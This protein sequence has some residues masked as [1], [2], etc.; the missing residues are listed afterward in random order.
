MTTHTNYTSEEWKILC[1]APLSVGGAVATASPSGVV[2]T[3]KEG[4][5]IVNGML[6]AA[7]QHPGNRLIQDV[8][9]M[10]INRKQIDALTNTARSMLRQT[11]ADATQTMDICRQAVSVLQSKSN[12]AEA[13]EYKLWLMEIGEVVADA[14]NEGTNILNMGGTAISKEESQMLHQLATALGLPDRE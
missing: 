9:P 12:P 7:H 11:Q 13:D 8:A 5:A 10:G 4:M 2:G 1:T 14:A 6:N 3:V